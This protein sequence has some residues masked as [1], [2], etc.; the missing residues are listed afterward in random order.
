MLTILLPP[1]EGKAP[2]GGGKPWA[3]ES[4]RFGTELAAHRNQVVAALTAAK[5]GSEK[6]LGVRGEALERAIAANRSVGGAPT[7]PTWR[8]F[9]GVVWDHLDVG[10]LEGAARRRARQSIVVVSALTGLSALTDPLPDHRLKLSVGLAPLGKLSTFWREPL[11]ATLNRSLRRRLVI[12]L[13]PQ[14]HAAAWAPDPVLYDLRRVRFA[15]HD[16]RTVGHTAKA[17]KG[18][19]ARALLESDDPEHVLATWT[20]PEVRAVIEPVIV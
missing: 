5:G 2:G 3:V 20:H 13:L 8:R 4:G 12:D 14:E 17:A 10:S 9:T 11:S 6:L 7:L 1:S 16:G 18:R 15:G 19:F